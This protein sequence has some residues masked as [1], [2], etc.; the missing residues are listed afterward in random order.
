MTRGTL[1]RVFSTYSKV[2]PDRPSCVEE[3]HLKEYVFTVKAVVTSKECIGRRVRRRNT[4]VLRSLRRRC[5]GLCIG[6]PGV[7]AAS[8]VTSRGIERPAPGTVGGEVWARTQIL[9]YRNR[10]SILQK[11]SH[12]N[13]HDVMNWSLIRDQSEWTSY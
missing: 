3:R 8:R 11:R 10:R 6:H 12:L 1:K 2:S 13:S 4:S 9:A 5:R 7:H